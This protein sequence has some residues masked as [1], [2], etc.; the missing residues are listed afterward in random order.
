MIRK[1]IAAIACIVA[2][3]LLV[4]AGVIIWANR[5]VLDGGHVAR[6]VDAALAEPAISAALIDAVALRLPQD[7]VVQA[8]V[9]PTLEQVVATPVFRNAM[10]NAVL[11]AHATLVDGD[12]PSV[13]LDLT[14]YL[15]ELQVEV[16]KIDPVAA[17]QI[18]TTTTIQV[19][20]AERTQLPVVWRIT[21]A[22]R[23]V[24]AALL[25]LGVSLGALGL[26]LAQRRGRWLGIAGMI[27]GLLALGLWFLT[28]V[29][30][31]AAV[32]GIADPT[33]RAPA[34]AIVDR[35]TSGLSTQLL[36]MAG[37]ATA[38]IAIALIVSR[39]EPEPF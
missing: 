34:D 32:E 11:A 4:A 21:A 31:D 25:V 26:V 36:A 8:A 19:L 1:P 3:V 20:I 14:E 9:R 16:A 29:A 27:A 12:E 7:P 38:A 6:E 35:L 13:L 30:T 22:M 2:P 24:A 17:Q 18:P 10:S 5:T 37:V 28:S 15:D 39:F 33:V 23:R